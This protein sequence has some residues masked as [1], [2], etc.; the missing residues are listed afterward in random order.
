MNTTDFIALLDSIQEHLIE[1][2]RKA[3]S[4]VAMVAPYRKASSTACDQC[5]YQSIC[6]IDPWTHNFRV[7][8]EEEE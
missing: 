1:M 6:R 4:G 2:A 8:R 5:D 3:F 7:L